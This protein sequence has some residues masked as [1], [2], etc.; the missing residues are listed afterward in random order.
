MRKRTVLVLVAIPITISV[1]ISVAISVVSIAVVA[2]I[3][4]LGS[5]TSSSA[6][7]CLLVSILVVAPSVVL[8]ASNFESG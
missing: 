2:T 1:A 6:V 7:Q 3:L 5:V 8:I 4:L